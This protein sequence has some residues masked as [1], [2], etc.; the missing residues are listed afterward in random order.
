MEAINK[1]LFVIGER[2]FF[3]MSSLDNPFKYLR[4]EGIVK[5]RRILPQGLSIY[6][7]QITNVL[8]T[9]EKINIYLNNQRFR[10]QKLDS[11]IVF[12]KRLYTMH[13]EHTK[14]E[15]VKE[16]RNYLFEAPSTLVYETS[17]ELAE[18]YDK[19]I[20]HLKSKLDSFSKDLATE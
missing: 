17:E 19:A 2:C 3:M 13:L 6:R 14:T 18:Y 20:V 4:F 9:K 10:V 7:I 12:A 15:F 5:T 16:Y 11:G 8:E 1:R